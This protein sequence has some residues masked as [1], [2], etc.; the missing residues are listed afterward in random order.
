M[1]GLTEPPPSPFNGLGFSI[2]HQKVEL[3]IDFATRTLQGKTEITINPH[4]KELKT[5]RLN[6]R[7]CTLKRLNF[8]GRVGSSKYHDPYSSTKIHETAGVHQHHMLRQKLDPYLRDPPDEELLVNL[9]KSV[10]IDELDPF[11]AEAQSAL[12]PKVNG[13]SKRDSGDVAILAV[14][15]LSKTAEEQGARFT[16]ITLTVEYTVEKI[17]D[18]LHFVG[19][20][21]GDGQYLHAY[22]RNSSFPGA[23]CC[24]FPCVDDLSS[25][26]TWEISIKCPRTLGDAIRRKRHRAPVNQVNGVNGMLANGLVN[27][28]NG[29]HVDVMEEDDCLPGYSEEDQGLDMAVI[30]SGDMTDEVGR[31]RD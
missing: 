17:R 13:G 18:G 5:I 9:P 22:S 24:L 26:C 2:L 20:E 14:T 19:W 11:S 1:V 23:A 29:D 25:R 28:A 12:L 8:N 3:D 6:C 10:R 7:Q 27:G 15:P 31:L 30:C 16:P 4:F 21:E